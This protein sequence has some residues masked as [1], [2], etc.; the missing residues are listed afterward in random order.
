[1]AKFSQISHILQIRHFRQIRHFLLCKTFS[2]TSWKFNLLPSLQIVCEISS[3]LHFHQIHHFQKLATWV[4]AN[5]WAI[6]S[7]LAKFAI[8]NKFPTFV[9]PVSLAHSL[10]S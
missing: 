4:V 8:F 5:L 9:V 6:H 7:N 2:L 3:D 1:M 10:E